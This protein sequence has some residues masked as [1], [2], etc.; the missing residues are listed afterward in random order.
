MSLLYLAE[1]TW[2]A[3][4]G[5]PAD[6][7]VAILPTG[8]VEAH[9]PHLPLVTDGVISEA[10][11]RSGARALH[12]DGW[13]VLLLPPLNYTAA[14]F[15]AEFSGT[16]NIR[17]E[18]ETALIV[19]LVRS[20]TAQRS[21][22][23]LAIANSH[24]DP[25]HLGALE[26][27][28]ATLR[29]DGLT[30]AFPNLT[31]KPWALRLTDEFKSGACHAGQFESSIVLAERPE[32]VDR[33]TAWRLPANGASLSQAIREGHGTFKAAGGPRAYFGNPAAATAD[34]GRGTIEILGQILRDAV[35]EHLGHP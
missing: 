35:V 4:E 5:L 7:L 22:R 23:C 31:R 28:V 18:T 25:T 27:A 14:P 21:C 2:K 1:M 30:V 34:E 26:A 19:D 9:G 16:I 10:M 33:E 15:A 3:V 20:F 24:L 6:S 12:Q 8:A 29:D 11:A 32:W 13:R 17:P